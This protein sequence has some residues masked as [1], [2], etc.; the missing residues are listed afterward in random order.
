MRRHRI[1]APQTIYHISSRGNGGQLIF[2]D[3]RERLR[4]LDLVAAVIG[5]MGWLC[6]AYCL[7]S[8]HYHLLLETNEENLSPGLQQ[9]NGRYAQ[10]FNLRHGRNGH[11]FQERF[12]SSIVD[13][14]EYF[15]VVASYIMLNPVKVAIPKATTSIVP[16]MFMLKTTPNAK[17]PTAR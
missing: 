15:M 8:N 7:M 12:D 1:K 6:H 2:A 13:T 11:L 5:K 4:F 14:D 17:I 10:I 9:L 3:D 16:T